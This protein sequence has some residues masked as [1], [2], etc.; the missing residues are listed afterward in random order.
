MTV[1]DTDICI[2]GSGFSGTFIAHRL[3][4]TSARILVVERGALLSRERIDGN[5]AAGDP[6]RPGRA[7]G[8][9]LGILYDDPGHMRYVH[10][11]TGPDRFNYSGRHAVGGNSL[12]WFGNTLRKVPNDFRTRSVYG[13]G[14]DWP[15]AYE[16]LEPY[17]Q[18]A[19]DEMLVA[20][21]GADPPAAFRTA[22]YPLP[23]FRLPPGA[24]EL[25]RIFKD[26]GLEFTPAPKARIPS[27]TPGRASCCGANTCHIYCPE[28]ARYSCLTTHLHG[29]STGGRVGMLEQTAVTRLFQRDDR[30]VE[31]AGIGPDGAETRI[32]ARIFVLAANAVENARILLLSRKYGHR[33][34]FSSPSGAIGRYLADQV[35]MVIDFFLPVNLHSGY[36]MTTQSSHSLS[37]Y[38]GPFRSER[39]G[40]V[41]EVLLNLPPFNSTGQVLESLVAGIT[42]GL[43]GEGLRREAFLHTMGWCRFSLEMEM[44]AEERNRVDLHPDL[45]DERGDP[46][47]SFHFSVWDQPYVAAS[48]RHYNSFFTKLIEKRGGRVQNISKR[49]SFDHMLGTC[50]MGED[51]RRSVVNANLRSHGHHNLYIAGGSAFTTPGITN[52]TLTI[53]AL[54]LRCADGI[55]ERFRL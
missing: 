6:F 41:V 11:N 8:E 25:N 39:S 5:Y 21:A 2:V 40:M 34:G 17:Y 55:K 48:L 38:D 7:Y 3:A 4:S 27:G 49:G 54:A 46:A 13:F 1:I 19:E 35:G 28:D 9:T 29:L 50:R 44:M 42:G 43:H 15:I 24:V 51:P 32:R 33:T 14:E 53:T 23:A 47:A 37:L 22:P 16:E 45:T 30:I 52:P 18:E 20:G 31:A 12:T 36:E 26:D 10:E